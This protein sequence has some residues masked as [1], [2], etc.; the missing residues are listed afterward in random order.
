LT[1]E[2]LEDSVAAETSEALEAVLSADPDS[3]SE[4]DELG[5]VPPTAEMAAAASSAAGQ[6]APAPGS[7]DEN[8][9]GPAAVPEPST[10]LLMIL[11]AATVVWR[12]HGKPLAAPS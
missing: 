9:T 1:E 6:S 2:T 8:S 5:P 10:C 3:L 11:T 4:S 7:G 12:R